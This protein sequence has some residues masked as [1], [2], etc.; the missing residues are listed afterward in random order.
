LVYQILCVFLIAVII[1][2]ILH[3]YGS[4][5][6]T[7]NTRELMDKNMILRAVNDGMILGMCAVGVVFWVVFLV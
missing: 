2:W 1:A 7:E 6:R 3:F 4:K 5:E